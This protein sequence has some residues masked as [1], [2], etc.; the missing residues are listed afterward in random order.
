LSKLAA[1]ML[2]CFVMFA[3]LAASC[4]ATNENAA[5]SGINDA[6]NAIGNA[7]RSV[8]KAEKL[9]ANV[10]G[11]VT[12]LN[13]AGTLLDEAETA[14]KNGNLDTALEKSDQSLVTATKV[15]DEANVLYDSASVDAQGRF[16][17]TLTFSTVGAV[18]FV[19]VL[20]LLWRWFS[21]SYVKK[22]LKMKAEVT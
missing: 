15:L 14:F 9:D 13:V 4:T 8:Q 2:I 17:V 12:D 22:M 3:A 21:R 5:S 10:S 7:L 19:I 18:L 11:L 6:E 16:L 1:S 20:V